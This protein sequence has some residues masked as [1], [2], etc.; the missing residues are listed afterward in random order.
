TGLGK[1]A[2]G[3]AQ[4][5]GA[6]KVVH[7]ML[8]EAC[9]DYE[10]HIIKELWPLGSTGPVRPN[11]VGTV[12]EDKSEKAKRKTEFMN[13]QL[14]TQIKE[15]RDTVE[16]TLV[17]SPLGGAGFIYLWW[18]PR[19]MRPAM[20]FVPMDKVYLPA[21]ASSSYA[22]K[23][24]TFSDT[25]SEVELRQ[26]ME[27]GLYRRVPL[28]SAPMM[29]ETS[30]AQQANDKIEG[31]KRDSV[32][33]VD[34]DRE[35]YI[36]STYLDVSADMADTLDY[37]DQGMIYPY[38]ITIDVNSRQVLGFY[39]NW[40]EGDDTRQAIDS[41]FE[42]PFVPWRGAYPIGFPQMIGGLSGAATGALRALLDSAMQANMQGG[43]I[44]KGSGTSGQTKTAQPGEFI[45]I[46]GG[47]EA[48]DV[49][50]KVMQFNTKE[51]SG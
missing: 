8:T 33:N 23:R 15:A 9:V 50:K 21:N 10:A 37:E 45:E 7:P 40:E 31:V 2:P 25:I 35:I 17:Q 28:G 18:D 30:K 39:R 6:S 44:L 22:A 51:P 16:E 5:E 41:L 19:L 12:T 13:Y 36:V 27:S 26:R 4:F 46:D 38:L 49:R 34:G 3:G 11:I 32:A 1:D 24:R 14:N 47:V 48:D 20:Q 29:P 43:L 42:F